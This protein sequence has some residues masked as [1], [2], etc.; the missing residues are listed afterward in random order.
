[1][2]KR[3]YNFNAG[4]AVL[5][6]EVLQQAQQEFLDYRGTGMSVM[7]ISHRSPDYEEI[8]SSAMALVRELLGLGENFKVLFL[9]GGASTQFATI[10]MNF[11]PAGKTAAYA[12]TGS[13]SAKAIK[14]AQKLGAVH[15][16]FSSKAQDYR[17]IPRPEEVKIPTDAAYLHVT[18][19]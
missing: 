15:V 12:D 1:M 7:E 4:P 3:V 18:S 2:A 19:N 16:A 6:L 10:P 5:P 14:E 11:L 8:N 17:R 13:W 9:G